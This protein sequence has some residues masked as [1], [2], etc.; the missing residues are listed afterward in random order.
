MQPVKMLARQLGGA[1]F[2]AR[3]TENVFTVRAPA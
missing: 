3:G 2:F 1:L